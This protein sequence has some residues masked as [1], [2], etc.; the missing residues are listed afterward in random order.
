MKTLLYISF[1]ERVKTR[2]SGHFQWFEFRYDKQH[3]NTSSF[4]NALKLND[5]LF[6]NGGVFILK[7][8]IGHIDICS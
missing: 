6:L 2:K 5:S 3:F 8:F 1:N 4:V 7:Q